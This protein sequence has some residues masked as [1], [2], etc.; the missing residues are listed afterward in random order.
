MAAITGIALCATAKAPMLEK[1]LIVNEQ[2]VNGIINMMVS[3]S[4]LLKVLI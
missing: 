1:T 2:I 4:S 3:S